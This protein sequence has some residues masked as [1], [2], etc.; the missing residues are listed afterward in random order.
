MA[1]PGVVVDQDEHARGQEDRIGELDPGEAPQVLVVE[2]VGSDAEAGEGERQFVDCCEEDLSADDDVDHAAE[3]FT[4][5]DG[6]LFDQLREVVEARGYGEGEEEEAEEK[7]GVALE[8]LVSE[9]WL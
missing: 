3:G 7:A 9:S 5:E 2:D 1:V 8:G 6:V 4:R